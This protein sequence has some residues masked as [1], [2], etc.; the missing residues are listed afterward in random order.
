MIRR[1]EDL[2]AGVLGF[3]AVATVTAEDYEHTIIPTIDAAVKEHGRI[4]LLYVLGG[5]FAGF[6]TGALWDDAKV[7]MQ[8]LLDFQRIAVVTD[9]S[10][11]ASAVRAMAFLMPCP[12]RLFAT[13]EIESARAWLAE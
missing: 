4:R 6:S 7:G 5:G 11:L 1:L 8:H 12:V 2:P 13:D 10:V 9:Q 3:E